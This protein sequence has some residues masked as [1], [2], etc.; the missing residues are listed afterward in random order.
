MSALASVAVLPKS[1]LPTVREAAVPKKSLFG[2][3]RDV[4]H[5]VLAQQGRTVGDYRWSGYVLATLLP[6]LEEARGISLMKSQFDELATFL[7][8]K[9]QVTLF[10]FTEEHKKWL[11]DLDPVK[12]TE[13]ELRDYYNQFNATEEPGAGRPMLDGV[14]FIRDALAAVD[15]ATVGLLCIG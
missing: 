12:F 6:Y 7:S 10:I 5:E 15:E 3:S 14:R 13:A 2:K 1:S 9:R 8:E 4:F 11:A